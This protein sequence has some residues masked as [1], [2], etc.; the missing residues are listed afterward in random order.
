MAKNGSS[1]YIKNDDIYTWFICVILY[2]YFVLNKSSPYSTL[3]CVKHVK[4]LCLTTHIYTNVAVHN[5][6]CFQKMHTQNKIGQK[7]Q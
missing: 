7:S 2:G 6:C 3:Q 1:Q 4:W 5:T